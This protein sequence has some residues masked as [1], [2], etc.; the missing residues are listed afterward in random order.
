M[1]FGRCHNCLLFSISWDSWKLPQ[2]S[3]KKLK[4]LSGLASGLALA[5]VVDFLITIFIHNLTVTYFFNFAYFQRSLF[6]VPP[7]EIIGTL[8][9]LTGEPSFFTI[10]SM[11]ET[12]VVII[13]K[14]NFYA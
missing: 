12:R 2:N 7:G 9:V 4:D 6:L 10:R 5:P 14:Q 11:M 8:A 13:S 1:N 3:S